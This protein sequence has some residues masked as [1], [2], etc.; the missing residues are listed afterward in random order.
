M[1]VLLQP[2]LW[3]STLAMTVPLALP[4]I[5][6]TFSERTGVVNIAMEGIM[7]IGA[8]FAVAFSYW[9]QNPWLGLLMAMVMGALIATVFA[10]A[11]IR[12]NSMLTFLLW[13]KTR[14][15]RA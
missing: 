3:A 9:T 14:S 6:G 1:D 5:G 10:W 2:Q 8:F 12:S 11:A 15:A 13:G 4:A 7:L